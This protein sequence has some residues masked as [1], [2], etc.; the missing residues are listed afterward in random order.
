MNAKE[1]TTTFKVAI[2]T[3]NQ[4]IALAELKPRGEVK[5]VAE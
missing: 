1:I 3:I 5:E 2:P 4:H